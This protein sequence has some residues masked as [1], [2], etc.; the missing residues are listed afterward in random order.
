MFNKGYLNKLKRK[1]NEA[2]A[3]DELERETSKPC[4]KKS[5]LKKRM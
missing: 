5:Q 3:F 1:H 2:E 4:E